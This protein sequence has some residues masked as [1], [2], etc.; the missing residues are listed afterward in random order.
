MQEKPLFGA[1][2]TRETAQPLPLTEIAPNPKNLRDDALNS[3]ER[4]QEMVT[5]LQTV[6]LIHP[7]VVCER[8]E[9]AK[10][11]PDLEQ[12]LAPEIKYVMLAGER[13]L[14][15]AQDAGWSTI[16]A[17]IRNDLLRTM[18][19]V[20]LHENG[21]RVDLNPFQEAEGYRRLQVD[22]GL[23]LADIAERNSKSK[24]HVS[25]RLRLLALSP[26]AREVV[27]SGEMSID[28]AYNLL[29]ALGD[30]SDL[31]L[32]AW[33]LM[34]GQE[35]SAKEAAQR[36]LIA[37]HDGSEESLP[38]ATAE[39]SP[40]FLSE[41]PPGS[42]ATPPASAQHAELAQ[43]DAPRTSADDATPTPDHEKPTPAS[44]Q[45]AEPVRTD[46]GDRERAVAAAERDS[47]CKALIEQYQPASDDL[48]TAR[49]AVTVVSNA[50]KPALT[51]AHRWLVDLRDQEA[52]PL[53]A[54]NYAAL[55]LTSGDAAKQLR[56]A[57]AIA[58]AEAEARAADRRRK[59]DASTIA[60][61]RHLIT[62]AGYTPASDW[63]RQ[64]L[65]M[66]PLS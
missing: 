65:G 35:I 28:T 61:V 14:L 66:A 23:T 31:V 30:R 4:R 25:K 47:R 37:P 64:Q 11:H 53:D 46:D 26:E 57:Y 44:A 54:K 6:G 62:A 20:F 42:P 16:K 10:V 1:G 58:L 56:L 13:R 34:R 59:W 45:H 48:A 52:A 2:R 63:E 60:H 8:T 21:R 24:S 36:V 17:E 41:T 39:P 19:E 22:D 3:A 5:S 55:T 32:P 7:V 18:N 33:E 27:L 50:S 29:S 15:G 43:S 12:T 51:L 9:Y 49:I 38:M 40:S